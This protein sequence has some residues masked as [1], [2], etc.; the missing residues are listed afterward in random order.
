[1]ESYIKSL[2]EIM[3]SEK[4]PA[5][6][7]K[8]TDLKTFVNEII[9]QGISMSI[10]KQLRFISEINELPEFA[11]IDEVELKRA[12]NNII[13]NAIDYSKVNGEV[14]FSVDFK[15]KY[16]RFI[17]EDSGRGFTKEELGSATEQF[18][19]G[20]K[21]R[22]SKSHYGMGLYIAKKFIER[23]N[24]RIYLSNSEKLGGAKVILELPSTLS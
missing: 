5:I 22:S 6:E 4:E 24:G 9:E 16:I 12:I 10:N 19:Q 20:D 11:L 18:F 21:S 2:I 17:I 7:K 3:K 8:K 13:S 23:H 1:M 14:I 15:D